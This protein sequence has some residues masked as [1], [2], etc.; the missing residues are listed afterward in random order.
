MTACVRALLDDESGVTLVEY[1]LIF[2]LLALG[3]I[4]AMMLLSSNT[5]TSFSNSQN[6]FYDYGTRVPDQ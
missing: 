6:E 2:A 5:N 3:S 4:A 1:G